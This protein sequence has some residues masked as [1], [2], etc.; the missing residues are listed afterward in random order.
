[1]VL[2]FRV[3]GEATYH[4][5]R[6]WQSK[7]AHF[8]MKKQ[9]R[10]SRVGAQVPTIL[11]QGYAPD[12]LKTFTKTHLLKIPPPPNITSLGTMPLTKG[13]WRPFKFQTTVLPYHL[14]ALQVSYE[15]LSPLGTLPLSEASQKI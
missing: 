15:M 13:L 3:C 9:K 4:G 1:M 5:G 8:V 6:L 2:L 12:D 11:F 7:S 14:F 10:K